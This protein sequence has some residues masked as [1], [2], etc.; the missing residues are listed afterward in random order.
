MRWLAWLALGSLVHLGFTSSSGAIGAISQKR[1]TDILAVLKAAE[2]HDGA[3]DAR[4]TELRALAWK[5]YDEAKRYAAE[6]NN[7][8]A[9]SLLARVEADA[10]LAV[11]RAERFVA[12][13]QAAALAA[14]V[15]AAKA[16]A[17][18]K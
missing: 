13:E 11:A 12:E 16:G 7:G 18:K 2:A 1:V 17:R 6:G 9:S 4:A 10:A 3:R 8:K 15:E 5:Q 14:R